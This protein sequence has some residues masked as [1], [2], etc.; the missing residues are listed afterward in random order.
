MIGKLSRMFLA[1]LILSCSLTAFA[2]PTYQ[3]GQISNLSSANGILIMLSSGVP[4][5]CQGTPYGWMVIPEQ[6]KAMIAVALL[7]WSTKPERAV[8][9]YTSG[10]VNGY[11]QINQIDPAESS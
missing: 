7:I 1:A 9:V 8:T 11:C 10:L 4:D 5:N 6:N 3:T 2:G